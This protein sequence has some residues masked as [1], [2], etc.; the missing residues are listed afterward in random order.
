MTTPRFYCPEILAQS[1]MAE[2]P[3]QAAHHAARV[4]RLQTGDRLSVFN[5]C[6]GEGEA[7]ITEIGKRN[8]TVEIEGWHTVERESPLKVQ[9]AQAISAG[10]KMDFT[11][12]KAVELGIGNIQPLASERSVVRLSGERAEKRVV[13]WQGVVIAACEQSG[14]NQVPEVA[15]IRPLLDW[16]GQQDGPGLRLMLS[17]VGEVGLRDLPKPTGNV[18][19]LIG[20]EGGLSPS[21]A[22]MAQ[23]YGFTPVRL[24]ARVLR[25]ETAALAAL[26]AMQTLWGD[27]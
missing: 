27:F 9:L 17:P 3:E 15:P 11:L 10:E 12:Q 25:T 5:G 16:L 7:R 23:R 22:E 8:V 2:L 6:G 1:A 13:H 14:R 4:L 24:G 19:L 20:P 18:T 21:E 26:A